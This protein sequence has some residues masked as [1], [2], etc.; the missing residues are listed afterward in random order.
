MACSRL[1]LFLFPCLLNANESFEAFKKA[2]SQSLQREKKSFIDFKKEEDQAF[3][4]Y[5]EK[6]EKAISDFKKK[7]R[8]FWPESD[9]EDADKHVNYSKDLRTKSLID[10]KKNEITISQISPK[11]KISKAELLKKLNHTLTLNTHE[12]FKSNSLEQNIEK[13]TKKPSYIKYAKVDKKPLLLTHS[14]TKTRLDLKN[15][16]LTKKGSVYKLRYKLPKNSTYKRSLSYLVA[17]KSNA[18]RFNLK[19]QWL[20]A[21]MHSES[22]FNPL[23]RSHIPAYGLMQIVPRSAGID[24]YKFLYKQRRLLSASY[25]Y[26]SKNNI[27]MGSTYL[28]ILY[29]RYLSSIKNPTSRLYCAIAAYN[30]GAGN[31]ARAFVRSNSVKKAARIINTMSPENVYHHLLKNLKYDEPKHYLKRVRKRSL[32]YKELYRL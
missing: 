27:E 12:A 14:R 30:T 13:I 32:T 4:A 18:R 20:L 5:R 23:A 29:Y 17:A 22:S 21:I 1:V 16:T 9:L 8:V 3:K 6:E 7:V 19:A 11:K 31:V 26:N 10:F 24:A 28:H 25:L 15:L 2:Q